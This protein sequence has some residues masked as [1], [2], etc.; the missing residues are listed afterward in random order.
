MSL[1]GRTDAARRLSVRAGPREYSIDAEPVTVSGL[2]F[3][4][5]IIVSAAS[6][7]DFPSLGCGSGRVPGFHQRS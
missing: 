6:R 5:V 7:G 4:I 1:Q 3:G 2:V